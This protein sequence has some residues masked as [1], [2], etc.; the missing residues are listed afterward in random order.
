MEEDGY[1][2]V[3]KQLTLLAK[4]ARAVVA[5]RAQSVSNDDIRRG[6]DR[7]SSKESFH[8]RRRRRRLITSYETNDV[9]PL[10]LVALL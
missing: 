7:S 10:S 1:I 5:K 6:Q 9:L 4:G 3:S 8:R 2:Y